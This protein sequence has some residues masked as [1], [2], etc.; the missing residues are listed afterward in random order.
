[1]P[2][3][4]RPW[5]AIYPPWVPS[6]LP[7]P[8]ATAID[9]FRTT[10]RHTPSAPAVY[11]FE[12]VITYDEVDRLSSRLAAAL[13]SLG[14]RPGDRLALF[15]QN[16]PQFWIAQLAAWKAGAIVVPLSP[17]FKFGELAHH[18]ADSGASFL[19]AL[20]SLV[21][22][23]ASP[24]AAI[25]TLRHIVT[26]SELDLLGESA[27]PALLASSQRQHLPGALDML[28]LCEAYATAPDPNAPLAPDD[29]AYLVYTSGTTGGP[30]GAMISHANV[31]F[32]A[33]VYRTW[34]KLGPGDV[35]V[36]A[37]PLFHVTGLVGHLAA[38]ALC[39]LPLI[40]SYRFD[41]AEQLRLIERWR[42]TF[43]IAAITAYIALLNQPDIR[44]NLA[45]LCKVY[46]GGAPIAPAIVEQFRAAS[47]AYIHN[48]YGLTET[49]SPSHANPLGSPAPIDA[50]TGALSIGV[51]VPNTLAKIVDIET[52]A[53]L[54]PGAIG[55]L[56]IKGPQIVPGYWQKPAESAHAI[57]D[58]WLF[59]G[60]VARMDE[61][62]YFYIVDRKKDMIIASG[63]KVWPR[64]VEDV[65][66][67]HP[68]VREAA[69][70][71]VPDAYRGQTVKAYVSLKPEAADGVDAAAL[72][73]FCRERLAAY[74]YPRQIEIVDE[75]PKTATGKILRRAFRP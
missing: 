68:A 74:K 20:E 37:A 33:E 24:L 7:L 71:G 21:A 41:P 4:E 70:V 65:L 52:A 58:G 25:A 45:S 66:Y 14:I 2:A 44:R 16:V 72:I 22:P 50:E 31:A 56:C 40:L 75:I 42:G 1:M 34:M 49:T 36:G 11:Y 5:L 62:G 30:K 38:A 39:S 63:Y 9:Q 54:P 15:L 61:R 28:A 43:M 47:G 29:I 12:T 51:P 46:S 13:I 53:E 73:A 26:T 64:D 55:E 17:M 6:D 32:N 67:R 48:I 35:L 57:R 18:L 3:S 69:V 19:I 10:A 60:D 23:I 59:T 27:R 8:C